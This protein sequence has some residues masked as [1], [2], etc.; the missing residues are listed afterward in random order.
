[1]R[2]MTWTIVGL[3]NPGGEYVQ[4]RHNAGRLVLEQFRVA[5]FFPEWATK[6]SYRAVVSVGDVGGATLRLVMP[7]TYMNDSGQSVRMLVKNKE[8]AL[9]LIV[10]Y[11]DIDLP[12]G[13]WKL[14]WNRNSGGHNGVNSLIASLKTK[15]FLRIRVG[16]SPVDADGTTNK[17]KGDDAV[18][19][20]VLGK[21]RESEMRLLTKVGT[22]IISAI[23][24][25]MTLDREH[26]MSLWN[27]K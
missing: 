26:A 24:D 8:D 14:S 4:T 11:D 5:H 9:R 22:E 20:F 15:E 2:I 25:I 19:K 6:K 17:P 13:T 3:G 27:K 1:M 7:E 21:F 23:P 12:L 18:L 10:L 16:I